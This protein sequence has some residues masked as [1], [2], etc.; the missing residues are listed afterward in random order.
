[1]S[2]K[3]KQKKKENKTTSESRQGCQVSFFSNGALCLDAVSDAVVTYSPSTTQYHHH[4]EF[5]YI[6]ISKGRAGRYQLMN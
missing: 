5:N 1:M 4:P 3:K 2:Q 6:G